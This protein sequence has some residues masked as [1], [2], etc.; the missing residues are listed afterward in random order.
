MA[1]EM[2]SSDGTHHMCRNSSMPSS[3]DSLLDTANPSLQKSL[4]RAGSV[5]S[6]RESHSFDGS[7]DSSFDSWSDSWSDDLFD[8]EIEMKSVCEVVMAPAL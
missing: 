2:I 8:N 1:E 3:T 5:E 6:F 4:I 7:F